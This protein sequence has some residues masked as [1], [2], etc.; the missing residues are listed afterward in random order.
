MKHEM[1]WKQINHKRETKENA[2]LVGLGFGLLA[3]TWY[4]VVIFIFP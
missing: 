1:G 3:I 2:V 4:L